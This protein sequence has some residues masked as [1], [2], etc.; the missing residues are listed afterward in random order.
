MIS[1]DS[2]VVYWR[3]HVNGLV[4]SAEGFIMMYSERG[5]LV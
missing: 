2:G 3:L 5:C 4:S 1:L